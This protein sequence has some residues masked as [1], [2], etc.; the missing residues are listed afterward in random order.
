MLGS[1]KGVNEGD[2]FKDRPALHAAGVHRGL[3]AGIGGGGFSIVLSGGYVDD[4]DEDD[5]IIYTGQGGRDPNT[6]RQEADQELS[7]GNR[8]LAENYYAGNPI[9][10]T[11]KIEYGP[12][13]SDYFYQYGGLYRIDCFW[14]ERGKDGFRVYRY[15]LVKITASELILSPTEP[16][17]VAFKPEESEETERSTVYTTR[18]IRNSKVA[19]YV[20]EMYDHRCQI[21]GV[22]LETPVGRYSEGCHIKPV[23]SPH[24]GPDT[25][26]NLLC[27]SPNMH[28]LFDKGAIAIGD[29]FQL[30][31]IEGQLSVDANHELDIQYIR[32]HREHIY[33][34]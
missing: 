19:N 24:D 20:K 5:V 21:S 22:V 7:R 9:R 4:V 6:G 26:S 14:C 13:K 12:K 34:S 3:Q 17:S 15:R 11:R 8:Q 23:G 28:V 27:L 18:V 16:T 32:Y 33:L 1:V 31:G 10:V 2:T 25:V 30:I 29:D